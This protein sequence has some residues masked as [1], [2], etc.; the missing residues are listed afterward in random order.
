MSSVRRRPLFGLA[1]LLVTTVA[2]RPAS[3]TVGGDSSLHVLGW[4]ARTQSIWVQRAPG[5]ENSIVQLWAINLAEKR[6]D[7]A[8]CDT[9]AELNPGDA[10]QSAAERAYSAVLRHRN[11]LSALT[12]IKRE[13]FR[14]AGL[15]FACTSR[16]RRFEDDNRWFRRQ[17]CRFHADGGAVSV[18]EF[19]AKS[20][21]YVPRLFRA[22][23]H[24]SFVLAWVVHT[25]IYELGYREDE[26][27]WAPR[28]ARREVSFTDFA[29]SYLP[30]K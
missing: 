17:T 23:G 15:H 18:L 8:S 7:F 30:S 12:P 14:A 16:A 3:A 24:P 21:W 10:P 29:R 22:P 19:S 13:G 5:G 1:A 2:A 20:D 27:G 25:G 4:D 26:L 11:K 6:V 28:Y 9:C